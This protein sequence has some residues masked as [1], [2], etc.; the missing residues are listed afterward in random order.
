MPYEMT[1]DSKAIFLLCGKAEKPTGTDGAKPLTPTEY[2]DLALWLDERE[3]RPDDLYDD[4]LL[5]ELEAFD[6]ARFSLKRLTAL[7]DRAPS[8]MLTLEKWINRNIWLVTRSD[9]D[10]PRVLKKKLGR[11]APPFFY[12]TGERE[13]LG[14]SGLGVVGSRDADGEALD[15]TRLVGNR[16]AHEGIIVISG[17]ARGV[18][19]TAML[20]CLE[21][22]GYAVGILSHGLARFS[23]TAPFRDFLIAERLLLLSPYCPESD[24]TAGAALGR[25]R[26]IFL[27]SKGTLA[28]SSGESGGTWSGAT[29]NLDRGWVPLWVRDG[30]NVPP[31]NRKLLDMGGK[32]LTRED[33]EAN[34]V[35]DILR[36][37]KTPPEKAPGPMPRQ[38]ENGEEILD[39]F[40][41]V[42]P[43]LLKALHGGATV[44]EMAERLCIVEEQAR[45]W[46][47][48][49]IN[50]GLLKRCGQGRFCPAHPGDEKKGSSSSQGPQQIFMFPE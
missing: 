11:S 35:L 21:N 16:C 18:D 4:A 47:E 17:G 15:F 37:Q 25:N 38:T 14:R 1:D 33:L 20:S 41:S 8:L 42:R 48:R 13:L 19:E 46:L 27:L 29:Q 45:I 36:G 23:M 32:P 50:E 9:D 44:A 26:Y 24:F 39:L 3:R 5:E 34:T 31:G 22:G 30:Q 49:G 28:V 6:P 43:G 7:F 2:S 12:G 10:Y 40:P